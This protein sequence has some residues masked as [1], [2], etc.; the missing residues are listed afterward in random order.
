[1]SLNGFRKGKGSELGGGTNG[2]GRTEK[3]QALQNSP[4]AQ[5]L[6]LQSPSPPVLWSSRLKNDYNTR[7]APGSALVAGGEPKN[8]SPWAHR[9]A[10]NS[11]RR[12]ARLRTETKTFSQEIINTSQLSRMG[13]H[14][15]R[16]STLSPRCS[17][18]VTWGTPPEKLC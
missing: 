15:A 4:S 1:M 9:T 13:K 3:T 6:A 5:L 12:N 14:E 8:L 18:A 16:T 11:G 7:E 2:T 10:A 17:T